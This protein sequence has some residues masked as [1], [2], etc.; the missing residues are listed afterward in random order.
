MYYLQVKRTDPMAESRTKERSD[1]LIQDESLLTSE[2]K[3]KTEPQRTPTSQANIEEGKNTS[4]VKNLQKVPLYPK[5]TQVS[6]ISFLFNSF[7]FRISYNFILVP[8][9]FSDTAQVLIL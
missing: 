8:F 6:I 1:I 5:T 2:V 7:L 9:C 4:R 3:A